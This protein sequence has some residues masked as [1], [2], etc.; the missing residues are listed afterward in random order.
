MFNDQL[1][2]EF[3]EEKPVKRRWRGRP[4]LVLLALAALL[5]F[6]WPG[7]AGFYAEW[8]WFKEVGYEK[9]FLSVL[10]TKLALGVVV[11][12]IAAFIIW[13]NLKLALRLSSAHS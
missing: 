6:L 3:E 4:W 1:D 12:L 9:V 8:F 11:A 2:D 10:Q 5:L 7:M 13:L